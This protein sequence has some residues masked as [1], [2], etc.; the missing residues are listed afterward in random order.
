PTRA[1][2]DLACDVRLRTAA[3]VFAHLG[4]GEGAEGGALAMQA[5]KLGGEV[6]G[7]GAGAGG[8]GGGG[9]QGP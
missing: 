7:A 9:R 3:G 1:R 8:A 4:T 5:G 2:A 6:G